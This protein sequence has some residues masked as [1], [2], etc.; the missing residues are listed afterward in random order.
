MRL[1]VSLFRLFYFPFRNS[2]FE[3]QNYQ[4]I[5]RSLTF[6]FS[7]HFDFGFCLSLSVFRLAF[8]TFFSSIFSRLWQDRVHNY[9]PIRQS[10]GVEVN[11]CRVYV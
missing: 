11:L 9:Y 1:N 10:V 4:V 7:F 5:V 2:K 6:S 3:I 8:R